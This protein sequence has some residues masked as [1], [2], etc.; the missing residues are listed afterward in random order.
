MA[1]ESSRRF[2]KNTGKLD[3][4]A[5]LEYDEKPRINRDVDKNGKT[6]SNK[7]SLCRRMA[8][9]TTLIRVGGEG[10]VDLG[11]RAPEAFS[12]LLRPGLCALAPGMSKGRLVWEEA[13]HYFFPLWG[14]DHPESFKDL[15]RFPDERN[16]LSY[17]IL[18]W[19]AAKDNPDQHLSRY[20]EA[21]DCAYDSTGDYDCALWALGVLK[22]PELAKRHLAK[23]IEGGESETV[24]FLFAADL[25]SRLGHERDTHGFLQNAEDAAS[26]IL[27]WFRVAEAWYVLGDETRFEKCRA[28]GIAAGFETYRDP[29]CEDAH[30][31]LM[32][33]SDHERR[34]TLKN[35]SNQ[36]RDDAYA[37]LQHATMTMF[38]VNDRSHAEDIVRSAWPV[39][40]K[41][42]VH[43]LIQQAEA[44]IDVLNDEARCRSCLK[45]VESL[46]DRSDDWES[47][48]KT[49]L[50]LLDDEENARR[51]LKRRRRFC[52]YNQIEGAV[53]Y[54]I[55]L[56]EMLDDREE[57]FAVLRE[58]DGKFDTV[59]DHIELA[60]GWFGLDDNEARGH[61]LTAEQRVT[62][63]HQWNQIA[64]WWSQLFDDQERAE[65]C[66]EKAK[67]KANED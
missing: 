37:R 27:D 50:R 12:L 67:I 25:A 39:S 66:R 29:F 35:W 31:G 7:E 38:L 49:W 41:F 64:M 1:T 40:S 53:E 9:I 52:R 55:S 48:A 63:S 36:Y 6:M 4:Q 47:I 42:P 45:E 5:H 19:A 33:S 10:V 28:K 57:A 3:E 44:W 30:T 14:F 65:Q 22:S 20:Q 58:I 62:Y 56:V 51:C 24:G 21:A 8:G 11:D 23:I 59:G 15:V 2:R 32:F 54:S 26:K 61:L 46:L 17:Q 60:R 43:D 34:E 16:D 18:E 13:T